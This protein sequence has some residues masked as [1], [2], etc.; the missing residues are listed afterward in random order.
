MQDIRLGQNIAALRR[1]NRLTQEQLAQALH[2]SA[3]AVSKWENGLSVPDTITIPQ[4]AEYFHVSI[5]FLY[6]GKAEPMQ[7]ENKI[8]RSRESSDNVLIWQLYKEEDL[9][10]L[11]DEEFAVLQTKLK[12]YAGS[13]AGVR[14][15]FLEFYEG[16]SHESISGDGT[17]TDFGIYK[18]KSM[19]DN[20]SRL[21]TFY[22]CERIFTLASTLGVKNYY[23]LGCGGELQAS[24]LVY[25]PDLTYTGVDP[26]IF[27]EYF[28]GFH[29]EPEYVNKVFAKFTG[30]SDRIKYIRDKYPCPLEIAE[31]NIAMVKKNFRKVD[32][33][34]ELLG[35]ISKNFE[36]FITSLAD[37]RI[38]PVL[39]EMPAKDFVYNDVP[40]WEDIFEEELLQLKKAMPEYEFFRLGNTFVFG[41]KIPSDREKLEK[42]YILVGDRLL[43]GVLDRHWIN[44]MTK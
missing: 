25:D 10:S 41:T 17:P 1:N 31:N 24:L 9:A 36:R 30:G 12:Y 37:R 8:D 23:D 18:R 43:S 20:L 28:D 44:K 2:I 42:R 13:I 29:A 15:S 22:R 33:G 4:I 34:S 5:D 40:V 19:A 16:F 3:Q 32:E 39:R 11:T 27:H 35:W 26:N 7:S 38:N 21:Y 14:A 6:Y